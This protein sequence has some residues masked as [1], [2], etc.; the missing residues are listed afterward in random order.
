MIDGDI[1]DRLYIA[2]NREAGF[3]LRQITKIAF[4][5]TREQAAIVVIETAQLQAIVGMVAQQKQ[6]GLSVVVVIFNHNMGDRRELRLH[7]KCSR[8]EFSVPEQKYGAS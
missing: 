8:N 5:V 1:D 2:G 3:R 4:P 7:G 6:I